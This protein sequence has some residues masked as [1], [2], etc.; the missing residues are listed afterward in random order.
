MFIKNI[1]VNFKYSRIEIVKN[2]LKNYPKSKKFKIKNILSIDSESP[3]Y[4]VE[5]SKYFNNCEK[6]YII[7]SNYDL[8]KKSIDKLFGRFNFKIS[9]D[10]ILDFELDPYI[11]YDLIIF[12][13]NFN[14]DENI[15]LFVKK[16]F[17][18]VSKDA[19]I[20]FITNKNDN[21]TLD[22]RSF[23]NLNFMSDF[24]FKEN[25]NIDCKIFNTHISTYLNINELTKKEMLKLTNIKLNDDKI[26]EF[27]NYA[28]KKYGE[29]VCVQV[30]LIIL[31]KL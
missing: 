30:S 2:W 19:I 26:K 27:K 14:L 24:E 23:F 18:L 1:N 13:K 6:Y 21:F 4:D 20:L 7:Q 12:F 9:Y 29:H 8:Y 16:T 22:T 3:E 17:E 5:V 31:S 15:S 25:L 10:D 28:L 11:S